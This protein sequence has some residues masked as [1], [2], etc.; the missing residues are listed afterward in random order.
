[1]A[2]KKGQTKEDIA[3]LKLEFLDYYKDVPIQKYAAQWIGRD[4]TTVSDWKAADPDFAKAIQKME[5]AFISKNL[6]KTK[7]E[8]KLERIIKSEFAQR[9]ELS[10]PDGKPIPIYGGSSAIQGHDGDQE[11]L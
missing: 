5:A 4:Q 9:T 2:S 1:M 6:L 11:G 7:A 8:F 10:G 3:R